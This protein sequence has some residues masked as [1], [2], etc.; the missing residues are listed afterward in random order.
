MRKAASTRVFWEADFAGGVRGL[1][2]AAGQKAS[3]ERPAEM[4]LDGSPIEQW[5][6]RLRALSPALSRGNNE[7]VGHRAGQIAKLKAG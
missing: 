3:I 2:A 6:N 5:A 1:Y 4:L 7:E